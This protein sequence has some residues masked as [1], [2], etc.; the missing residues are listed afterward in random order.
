[1]K[2]KLTMEKVDLALKMVELTAEKTKLENDL[3]EGAAL[4]RSMDVRAASAEHPAPL[5]DEARLTSVCSC[6]KTAASW[7]RGGSS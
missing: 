2:A 3:R 6:S 4:L 7:S 5:G 1:M